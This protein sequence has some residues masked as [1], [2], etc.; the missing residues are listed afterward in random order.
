MQQTILEV[1]QSKWSLTWYN[2]LDL[3]A[4]VFELNMNG[5]VLNV[6]QRLYLHV[7]SLI[8]FLQYSF[9]FALLMAD[10]HTENVS[11]KHL[12]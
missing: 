10:K 12:V 2:P 11:N 3:R 1:V 7:R 6:L 9:F 4:C 8:L 5:H